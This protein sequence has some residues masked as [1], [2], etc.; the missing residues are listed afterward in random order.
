MVEGT[1]WA[2]VVRFLGRR[3]GWPLAAVGAVLFFGGFCV[4]LAGLWLSGELGDRA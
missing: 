2:S 3:I 1:T 4:L